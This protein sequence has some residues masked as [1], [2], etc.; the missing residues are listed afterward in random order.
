MSH[1]ICTGFVLISSVLKGGSTLDVFPSL[2]S[3]NFE[4]DLR[5]LLTSWVDQTATD[6]VQ[7]VSI[8]L[9]SK[10]CVEVNRTRRGEMS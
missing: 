8:E 10:E 4:T 6:F 3:V 9:H 1:Y 2:T 7:V 5:S